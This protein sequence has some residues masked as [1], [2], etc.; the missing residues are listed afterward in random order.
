M[1]PIT[2]LA[3]KAD[4]RCFLQVSGHG[5]LCSEQKMPGRCHFDSL[6]IGGQDWRLEF[7]GPLGIRRDD[8]DWPR[9]PTSG[10]FANFLHRK[11]FCTDPKYVGV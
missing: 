4:R 3:W 8:G 2:L 10:T 5:T 11:E 9:L 7:I 1:D 6:Q